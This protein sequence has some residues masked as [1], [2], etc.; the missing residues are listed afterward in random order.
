[1]D[2]VKLGTARRG[3]AG[4]PAKWI[5]WCECPV[6]Y[7]GQ[8]CE[9]C[10]PGYRHDPP[11]GGPFATCIPCNCYNHSDICDPDTGRVLFVSCICICQ[12]YVLTFIFIS[13]RL[14]EYVRTMHMST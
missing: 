7:V 9:S 5:E 12:V 13:L 10:G 4:Q 8:F 11:Y 14:H 3:A 1:M 6:G 2:D